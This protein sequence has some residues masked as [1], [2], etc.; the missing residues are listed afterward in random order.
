[1]SARRAGRSEARTA[2]AKMEWAIPNVVW[3]AARNPSS[4][5]V[6]TASAVS[7]SRRD[8]AAR[9]ARARPAGSDRVGAVYG[10]PTQ[11]RVPG[12][13]ADRVRK[14]VVRPTPGHSK[15]PR[16]WGRLNGGIARGRRDSLRSSR[17]GP[18]RGLG[19][20]SRDA[21]PPLLRRLRHQ[22]GR[23]EACRRCRPRGRASAGWAVRRGLV[24]TVVLGARGGGGGRQVSL[25]Q[26]G[27]HRR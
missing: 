10:A 15:E 14:D 9:R 24:P 27:E 23:G 8:R 6:S 25:R 1:M 12:R 11:R 16:W 3:S 18:R 7:S 13:R 4:M 5:S 22:G 19:R 26:R 20:M 17:G 21:H 2:S